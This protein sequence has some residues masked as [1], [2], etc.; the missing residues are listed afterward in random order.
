M[1]RLG[2]RR[3]VV[4][5]HGDH[6]DVVEEGEQDHVP[7]SCTGVAAYKPH[8]EA[9]ELK[10]R[11][12]TALKRTTF[13]RQVG[14]QGIKSAIEDVDKDAQEQENLDS[15]SQA[16]GDIGEKTREDLPGLHHC[17]EDC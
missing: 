13:K 16:V 5:R 1:L 11:V 6:S 12:K 15:G 8:D 3:L 10:H 4:L 7:K 14:V 17:P 9:R 2:S